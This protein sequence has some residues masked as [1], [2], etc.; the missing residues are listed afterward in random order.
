MVSLQPPDNQLVSFRL[1]TTVLRSLP[2]CLAQYGLRW[3]TATL[4]GFAQGSFPIPPGLHSNHVNPVQQSEVA[5]SS[6]GLNFLV[7]KL[8]SQEAKMHTLKLPHD[9]QNYLLGTCTA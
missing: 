5:Q 8:A 6:L 2:L 7:A 4:Q 1:G 9:S 3:V